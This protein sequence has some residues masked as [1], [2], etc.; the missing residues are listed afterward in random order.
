MNLGKV[1]LSTHSSVISSS[2]A[3]E[4]LMENLE[5]DIEKFAACYDS[6]NNAKSHTEPIQRKINQ[7]NLLP[8]YSNKDSEDEVGSKLS[9]NLEEIIKSVGKEYEKIIKFNFDI[10]KYK[11]QILL[12]RSAL[13]DDE[14]ETENNAEMMIAVPEKLKYDLMV[15]KEVKR[16]QIELHRKVTNANPT[17]PEENIQKICE[18]EFIEIYNGIRNKY[19]TEYIAAYE[20]YEENLQI[21]NKATKALKKIKRDK[22][23]YTVLDTI[24]T[25]YHDATLQIVTKVKASVEKFPLVAKQLHVTVTVRATGEDIVNP[26]DSNNLSGMN[27]CLIEKYRKKTFI[28]FTNSL[29]DIMSFTV[30]NDVTENSPWVAIDEMDINLYMWRKKDFFQHMTEDQFFSAAFLKGLSPN[31]KF[32]RELIKETT[33]FIRRRAENNEVAEEHDMPIYKFI[34]SMISIERDNRKFAE[35]SNDK[36]YINDNRD[37]NIKRSYGNTWKAKDNSVNVAAAECD[38]DDEQAN[39]ATSN[40]KFFHGE[41]Y[42]NQNVSCN[43]K[44]R[45]RPYIAVKKLSQICNKCY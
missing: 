41:V 43:F 39:E 11:L 13:D 29:I 6:L 8:G 34:K 2:E 38:L 45:K 14:E 36:L 26:Y 33:N 31:S 42:K 17:E 25:A 35:K 20:E 37:S 5:N 3:R 16:S 9:E 40:G 23:K 10:E 22:I 15:T 21:K 24:L 18:I 1:S 4:K 12:L 19:D 44:G 28:T 27:E 32:R 30:S 7:F